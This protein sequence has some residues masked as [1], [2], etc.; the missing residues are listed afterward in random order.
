[1]YSS[2]LGRH[3][4]GFFGLPKRL[5]SIHVGSTFLSP[6]EDVISRVQIGPRWSKMW[7][8]IVEK[9]DLGFFGPLFIH[10]SLKFL[11]PITAEI[12]WVRDDLKWGPGFSKYP[13]LDFFGLLFIHVSS[14]FLSSVTAKIQRVRD[15]PR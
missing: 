10:V 4:F 6:I 14:K 5:L 11:S 1:M 3:H 15:D 2:H 7:S 8:G 13:I 12:S 9:A